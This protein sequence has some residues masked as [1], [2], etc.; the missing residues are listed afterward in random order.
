[1]TPVLWIALAYG[2]VAI[3]LATYA[4]SLRRRLR[5][6]LRARGATGQPGAPYR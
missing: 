4:L 6:A 3:T 5:D 1:M 2:I